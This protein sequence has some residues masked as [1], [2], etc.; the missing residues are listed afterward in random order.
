MANSKKNDPKA[1]HLSVNAEGKTVL[2][3]SDISEHRWWLVPALMIMMAVFAV[4]GNSAGIFPLPTNNRNVV[5]CQEQQ[6]N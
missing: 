5:N 1:I 4:A 2:P 3:Y 6:A